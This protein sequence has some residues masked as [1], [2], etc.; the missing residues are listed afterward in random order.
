MSAV[1]QFR[2]GI[3]GGIQT[4]PVIRVAL[5]IPAALLPDMPYYLPKFC[6]NGQKG[7]PTGRDE[8]GEKGCLVKQWPN[9]K[10]Q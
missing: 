5:H 1:D 2:Q 7:G 4:N 10:H 6:T 8:A 3:D 9:G